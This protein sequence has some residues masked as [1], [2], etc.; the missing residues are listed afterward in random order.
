ML[1]CG[2]ANV[3]VPLLCKDLLQM[4]ARAVQC[5]LHEKPTALQL[6]IR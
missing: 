1:R 5:M 4:A 3:A 2:T 6:H